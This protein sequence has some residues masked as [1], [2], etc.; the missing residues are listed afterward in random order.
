LPACRYYIK[1]N[2]IVPKIEVIFK[3]LAYLEAAEV[4]LYIFLKAPTPSL[5]PANFRSM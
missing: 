4:K 2:D 1:S 3:M 5:S